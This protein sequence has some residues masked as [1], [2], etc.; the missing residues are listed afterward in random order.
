MA[1]NGSSVPFRNELSDLA[2]FNADEFRGSR[3]LE[4]SSILEMD[5]LYSRHESD[6]ILCF[7]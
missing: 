1:T 6:I 2:K 5:F 7:V 4:V 3:N